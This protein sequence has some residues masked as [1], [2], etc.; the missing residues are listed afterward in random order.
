MIGD[1]EVHPTGT[2]ARLKRLEELL[3]IMAMSSPQVESDE[4]WAEVCTITG[5]DYDSGEKLQAAA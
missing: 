1:F 4:V 2:T 3:D 5:R